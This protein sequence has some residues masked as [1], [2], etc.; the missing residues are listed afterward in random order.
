L[1]GVE[2]MN[3]KLLAQQGVKYCQCSNYVCLG[4]ETDADV[5][6]AAWTGLSVLRIGITVFCLS[7]T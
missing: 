6:A 1:S 7:S 4:G 3:L 5:S 2:G